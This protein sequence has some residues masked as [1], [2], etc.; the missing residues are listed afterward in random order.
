MARDRW[1]VPTDQLAWRCDPDSLG[2]E[3]TEELEPLEGIAGQERAIQA[4]SFGLEVDAPGYNL[5]LVGLPGTGRWRAA[6]TQIADR[7]RTQPTPPDWCYVHN[8]DD[9]DQPVAFSLPAGQGRCFAEDVEKVVTEA[10]T[11]I[12]KALQTEEYEDAKADLIGQYSRLRDEAMDAL[13]EKAREVDYSLQIGPAGVITIP[14]VEGEPLTPE[15]YGQLPDEQR[16]EIDARGQGLPGLIDQTF[17]RV[18]AMERE[19]AEKM[20]EMEQDVAREAVAPLLDDLRERHQGDAKIARFLQAA[21]DDIVQ[22]LDQFR[23]QEHVPVEGPPVANMAATMAQ[24]QQEEQM[25]HYQVNVLVDNSET[26]GAPMVCEDHPTYYNLIGRMDFQV[27][28]GVMVT[29]PTMIKPGSILRANGGYLV[30]DLQDVLSNPLA[31]DGLKRALRTGEV[32]LE[33]MG[34]QLG[35]IPTATLKPEPIPVDVK[36]VLIGQPMFYQMLHAMDPDFARL[37]KVKA[38]FDVEMHRNDMHLDQYAA[39][40]A[41]LCRRDG[42]RPFSKGAFARAA[43]HAARLREHQGKLA[44]SYR[45][46]KDLVTEASLQARRHGHDVVQAEDV[47]QAL[48]A[49]EYRSRMLEEKIQEMIG[50]GTLM[51]D[52]AGRVPAQ[53]NGLSVLDLG[54]YAFGRPSR[55]TARTFLGRAGVVNIEREVEM[56]GRIHNKGILILGGYLGGKY[57]RDLPLSLSATL[58]FEQ[59]YDSVEGDSASSAE[60]YALLSS[61]ADLPISQGIAVTGSVNQRG[62][63]QPIG[64][65]TQKVE[66]FYHVCKLLGLTGGQGVIIPHQNVKN[67]MLKDEVIE[68]VRAGRF[69]IWAVRSV[70]EGIEIL[71]GVRAGRQMVDGSFEEGTVNDRVMWRLRRFADTM[72]KFAEPQEAPPQRELVGN[73]R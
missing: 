46:A 26:E 70:D 13:Q 62:E 15:Q 48:E 25:G 54:D 29:G 66:G 30:L 4:I 17:R 14:I 43:E 16:Q 22:H 50:E 45:A 64:G 9:P 11:V 35:L 68:A 40:V 33:N 67:L 12:P 47:E 72:R 61:L 53:V 34:E 2:F 63:V 20:Q 65:V 19:M 55:I 6:H 51:I 71:T 27:R 44:T 18:R 7:A 73:G 21:L 42:I 56:G 60:L 52:V 31:W 57:A 32:R 23:G 49:R 3:T 5:F 41:G 59:L 8:F 28:F 37:F 38:D 39:L 36:V 69:H 1:Q 58:T 10:G 24:M